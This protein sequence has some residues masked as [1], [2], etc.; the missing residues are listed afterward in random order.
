MGDN[1]VAEFPSEEHLQ[2]QHDDELHLQWQRVLPMLPQLRSACPELGVRAPGSGFEVLTL[3]NALL[4]G[5]EVLP[6]RAKAQDPSGRRA[7][8]NARHGRD[9]KS[10]V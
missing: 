7:A 9:R 10:V 4:P 8:A 5:S 3:S 6:S 1:I 2:E